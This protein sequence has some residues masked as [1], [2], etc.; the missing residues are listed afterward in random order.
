MID[1]KGYDITF[2]ENSVISFMNVMIETFADFN[3][4]IVDYLQKK[5]DCDP[6]F[7]KY[8]NFRDK[9][10]VKTNGKVGESLHE[11]SNYQYN[12]DKLTQIYGFCNGDAFKIGFD[13]FIK[14]VST[15]DFSN[16]YNE[17]ETKKA[18]TSFVISII[19]DYVTPEEWYKK[20][21]NS[22]NLTPSKCSGANVK[23]WADDIIFAIR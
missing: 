20:A 11:P 3:I 7:F 5:S 8:K 4:D 10:F 19:K 16:I 17:K 18:K 1:E 13:E 15:A 14:A 21:A 23:S 9:R 22:I 6:D 12:I 2:A